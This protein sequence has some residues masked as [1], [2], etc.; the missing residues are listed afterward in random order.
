MNKRQSVARAL[1]CALACL[2]AVGLSLC[3]SGC[4]VNDKEQIEASVA[5]IMDAF[6]D[7]SEENLKPYFE[8]SGVDVSSFDENGIDIYEFADHVFKRFDYEIVEV[9]VDGD[10]GLAK[11]KLTNAD[12]NAAMDDAVAEM[13]ENVD[14]YTEVLLG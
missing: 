2:L 8:G 5:E 13:S 6:K 10:T 11:L 12:L 1:A 3:L 4:G 14:A 7:P 9:G